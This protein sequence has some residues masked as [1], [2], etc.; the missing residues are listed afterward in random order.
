VETSDAE[1]L[2]REA[3]GTNS[4]VLTPRPRDRVR[5]RLGRLALCYGTRPQVVKASALAEGLREEWDLVSIDTGQHYDWELHG[6]HYQQLGVS[7]PDLFLEVKSATHA[8]QTSSMLLRVS[9]ALEEY[10]P[11]VVVVIGDTNSTLGCALAAA[12]QRIYLVHVEAGLR[13]RDFQMAEEINR[14]IVDEI[15]SLLCAP[16]KRSAQ[17]LA[18]RASPAQTVA[19]TGDVA[20][21]VL[22]RALHLPELPM[23]PWARHR[24]SRPYVLATLHRAELTSAGDL[25]KAVVQGLGALPYPVFLPAHP[26]TIAA[27]SQS[28]VGPVPDN[29][30]LSAPVGYLEMIAWARHA[31]VIVTDSGGLQREAYW[32]GIPCVTMRSE[33][34]WTETVEEG[35]NVLVPPA[36]SSRLPRAVLEHPG[37]ETPWNGHAYGSGRAVGAVCDALRERF[38]VP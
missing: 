32:M 7:A 15:S 20:R 9:A 12:K 6:L 29:I 28:G 37:R 26:R 24:I 18:A 10:R 30:V 21:D 25:L 8:E 27:L 35:A 19:F 22:E 16:S 2:Y 5:S 33:T 31:D 3:T 11:D 4:S 23:A 14:R 36:E 38:G 13:A 17:F 1:L 34:E